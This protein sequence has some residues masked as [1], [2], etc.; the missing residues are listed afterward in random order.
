M[1]NIPD[2]S[3]KAPREA[4]L[5]WLCSH[6]PGWSK[7]QEQALGSCSPFPGPCSGEM[8][9]LHSSV[10]FG[11]RSDRSTGGSAEWMWFG[12][13]RSA[14]AGQSGPF[15]EQGLNWGRPRGLRVICQLPRYP[16]G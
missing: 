15:P 3:E 11:P 1:P 7:E 8:W 16:A 2:L 6:T 13:P 10:T 14:L 9:G 12:E 5:C 4:G